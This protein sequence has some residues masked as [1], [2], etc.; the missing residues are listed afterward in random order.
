[1]SRM[2]DIEVNNNESDKFWGK[3][4]IVR[5]LKDNKLKSEPFELLRIYNQK[6]K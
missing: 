1:M 4:N 5:F 3:D 2:N 6:Y